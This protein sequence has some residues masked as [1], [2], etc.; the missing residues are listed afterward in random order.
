MN[1]EECPDCSVCAAELE[2]EA[3][4]FREAE[5]RAKKSWLLWYEDHTVPPEVFSG[6]GAEQAA[7]LSFLRAKQHWTCRLFEE[8]ASS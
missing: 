5:K 1:M 7:R 4:W 3:R 6:F 2:E 8:I